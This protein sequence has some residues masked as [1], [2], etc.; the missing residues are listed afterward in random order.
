[1]AVVVFASAVPGTVRER[2]KPDRIGDRLSP[3]LTGR[4]TVMP[5]GENFRATVTRVAFPF[6]DTPFLPPGDVA[7][8]GSA[9]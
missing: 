1:M 9:P 2:R 8:Y 6:A 3:A 7:R 4:Q 5:T